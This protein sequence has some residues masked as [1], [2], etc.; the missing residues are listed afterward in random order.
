MK[1]I[2]LVLLFCLV[3]KFSNATCAFE[4]QYIDYSTNILYIGFGL[5]PNTTTI[6]INYGDSLKLIGRGDIAC[7][8][9]SNDTWTYNGNLMTNWVTAQDNTS[10]I[11]HD[12]GIYVSHFDWYW[13]V[14][15]THTFEIIVLNAPTSIP[16]NF[17]QNILNINPNPFND[18]LEINISVQKPANLTYEIFDMYGKKVKS[19]THNNFAG[20]LK[21]SENFA[22]LS[23]GVY[24]FQL[25]LDG[26]TMVKKL[27]HQ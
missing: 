16:E 12:G 19:F 11:V 17:L 9:I 24:F 6:T 20:E 1:K 18:K 14:N 21:Q 13:Y 23:A 22:N 3:G 5:N 10:I 8:S 25:T 27:V 4:W 2:I 15:L 26:E 7:G